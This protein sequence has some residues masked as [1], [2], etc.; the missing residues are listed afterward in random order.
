MFWVSVFPLSE[1]LDTLFPVPD[2]ASVIFP[3]VELT[4]TAPLPVDGDMVMLLP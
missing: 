4:V 1:R 3:A 2:V